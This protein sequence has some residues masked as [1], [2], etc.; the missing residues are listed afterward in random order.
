MRNCK[1]I[2]FGMADDSPAAAGWA[3]GSLRL[4]RPFPA[5]EAKSGNYALFFQIP[6]LS[7][8]LAA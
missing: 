6:A 7:L 3:I 1:R 5:V 2:K 4:I 8:D